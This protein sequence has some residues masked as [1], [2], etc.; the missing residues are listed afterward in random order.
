MTD[1]RILVKLGNFTGKLL[2]NEILWL[3]QSKINTILKSNLDSIDIL[4]QKY[5]NIK[6]NLLKM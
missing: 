4:D 2:G 1:A 3:G 5:R 6:L